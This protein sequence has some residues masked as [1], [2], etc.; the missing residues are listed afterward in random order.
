MGLRVQHGRVD[1]Y[2][3][4][5]YSTTVLNIIRP[6]IN[7]CSCMQ[8]R[9]LDGV[10][11]AQIHT[12]TSVHGVERHRHRLSFA[13]ASR[14]THPEG[15]LHLYSYSIFG[16]K[17]KLKLKTQIPSTRICATASHM[18][19]MNV[20]SVCVCVCVCVCVFVCVCMKS[21]Y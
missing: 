16:P 1:T 20:Q 14:V 8:A 6:C 7:V 17:L 3:Y 4:M 15:T 18:D 9:M 10:V 12:H 2:V 19:E 13:A 5:T 11:D 21:G